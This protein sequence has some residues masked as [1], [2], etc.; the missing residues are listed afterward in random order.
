LMPAHVFPAGRSST[1]ANPVA[2]HSVEA[3]HGNFIPRDGTIFG[4]LAKLVDLRCTEPRTNR[5]W[6]GRSLR[7]ACRSRRARARDNGL[8][9]ASRNKWIASGENWFA[10]PEI[11]QSRSKP[12]GDGH[13]RIGPIRRRDGRGDWLSGVALAG[14]NWRA[15]AWPGRADQCRGRSR[16]EAGQ[17]LAIL[18]HADLEASLAAVERLWPAKAARRTGSS[19][20][21]GTSA[22]SSVRSG[23]GKSKGI[24]E[25]NYDDAKFRLDGA[26]GTADFAGCRTGLG[27]SPAR[28]RS[29]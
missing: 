9:I 4:L 20:P 13:G 11:M 19:H 17:V 18:E 14:E 8:V 25:S 28:E 12:R 7:F 3:F 23:S 16:V 10:V 2:R 5:S 27:R 24:A 26:P 29:R 6:L 15:N 1:P 22:I 21:A